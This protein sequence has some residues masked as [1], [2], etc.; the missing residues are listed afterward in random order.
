MTDF[1]RDRGQKD[2]LEKV[3]GDMIMA[4]QRR[5]NSWGEIWSS[6]LN[7]T[8]NN[9]RTGTTGVTD[10]NGNPV[11]TDIQINFAWP[12]MMQETAIQAQR[13]PQIFVEPHDE[14]EEDS[15][16]SEKWQ[17]IL[18]HQ[19]M[20]ELGM[21]ELNNA[22]SIDAFC[23]GLYIAKVFWEPQAEWDIKN[24]RW[25]GKPQ[26]NL[27]FPP[28][29]GA[30]PEA[31][32]IDL[33]T[34]YVYSGRRVSL[35]WVLR[36]WGTSPEM[37]Q[38]ITDAA[39]KDPYN[40]EYA[41]AMNDAWNPSFEPYGTS[42]AELASSFQKDGGQDLSQRS[43]RGRLMR[44]ITAARGYGMSGDKDNY[45]GRPRKL[46]LFEV[47]FRDL[48]EA[49][50]EDVKPITGEELQD[51]GAIEKYTDGSWHVGNPEAFK[52]S[53]P[54]LQ[55]GDLVTSRDWP[56]RTNKWREPTF[57]RGRFVL[58]IGQDLVLNPKEEDQ[59]YP[60]KR[61]PY[62]TGVFHQ[63]PHIWEGLNGTEMSENL[64]T[65]INST[66]TTLLNLIKYH[67]DPTLEVDKSNMADPD[68]NIERGPGAMVEVAPGKMGKVAQFIERHRGHR[69]LFAFLFANQ[70]ADGNR[71]IAQV[72]ARQPVESVALIGV[73]QVVGDHGV[74]Q[75]AFHFDARLA[76][77]GDVEL[78]IVPGLFNGFVFKNGFERF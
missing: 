27:L 5:T 21:P 60:Y 24:R 54:H 28:Y 72:R 77:H 62:I 30:D 38:K 50:K 61:W 36:R 63:L 46:T 3:T 6:G 12:N 69:N 73:E 20:H 49:Q 66:Y 34:S 25:I 10:E 35:D 78:Q 56:T 40:T 64:Q 7:Q 52:V 15:E 4:G 19:Y 65:M 8:Y 33:A 23:F 13:R 47:Y 31:E 57:P 41:R 43:S 2:W 37:E 22:A 74:E 32:A 26:A 42:E 76:Q 18:Q 9:Q 68:A 51:S 39:E 14:Q 67:G 29:F 11:D 45:T 17:G 16:Q 75:L 44:M 70:R 71:L 48:T 55:E 59:V 1:Y 53:A 58:K